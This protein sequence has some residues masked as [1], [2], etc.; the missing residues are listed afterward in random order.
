MT[1]TA[2]SEIQAI[3]PAP[4]EEPEPPS[5]EDRL[6]RRTRRRTVLAVTAYVVLALLAFLPYGPFDTSHIPGAILHS[7]AGADPLQMMWFLTWV[8]YAITHGLNIFQTTRFEYPFGANLADNTTV[9]LLGL[10]AWPVTAT[11]GPVAAF[12]FLI[13]L[14]FAAD[15]IAM[16]FALRR[17]TTS[18]LAAFVGGLLYAFGPYTAGQVLHI[19]LI[20]VPIPPLLVLCVEEFVKRQKMR[21]GRLGLVIGLL[22][23]A[24]LYVSQDILSGCCLMLVFALAGLGI[25]FRHKIRERLG[26]MLRAAGVAIGVFGVLAGYMLWEMVDGPRHLN[27]PIIKTSVLQSFNG[28]V[29][30]PF[31]PT[32][33]QLGVPHFLSG[34]GDDFVSH[35]LSENGTYFGVPLLLLLF[36]IMRRLWN[37]ERVRAFFW[38]AVVAFVTAMGSHLTIGGWK[39]KVP[40]PETVFA[41]LPLLDNTIP[42]RYSLYVLLFASM[43]L[44]IGLDRLWLGRPKAEQAPRLSARWRKYLGPLGADTTRARWARV[45]IASCIIIFSLLPS[46]PFLQRHTPWPAALEP[47]IEKMIKPG[48][49]VLTYPYATPQHPAGMVWQAEDDMKF[50]LLGGYANLDTHGVDGRWPAA[51]IPVYPQKMLAYTSRG[52]TFGNPATPTA[53]DYAALRTLLSRYHVG[54][55]V[56]WAGGNNREASYDYIRLSLGPPTLREHLF[57]IWLPIDGHWYAPHHRPRQQ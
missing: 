8:P 14:C 23:T 37:D 39:T 3:S 35:N 30:G 16:F 56:Y 33:N 38:L 51:L 47:A 55:V 5:A 25:R 20:F 2:I 10:I 6:R 18:M 36:V 28:N 21:P 32:S 41:H 15:G 26:Y 49:V 1:A 9:P 52:G 53:A 48:T 27:G 24:Q 7:P 29:L 17:W 44:G 54:A 4:T 57:A 19:D 34:I 40:L 42:A 45:G 12:N 50:K 11:L 46:A 31:F 13:R 22:A 43:I